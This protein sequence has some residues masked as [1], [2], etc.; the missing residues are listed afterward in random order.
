[1]RISDWSSDVCSSDLRHRLLVGGHRCIEPRARVDDMLIVGQRGIEARREHR[2]I[3]L[4]E[5]R[6][7]ELDALRLSHQHIDLMDEIGRPFSRERVCQYVLSSV[8]TASFK[9]NKI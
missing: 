8:V 7:A 1:M 6:A 9:R 5:A 4:V 3:L 2:A